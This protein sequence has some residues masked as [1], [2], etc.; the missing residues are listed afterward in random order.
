MNTSNSSGLT[1]QIFAGMPV[2][3]I[4]L[5]RVSIITT[6]K[7]GKKKIQL[8]GRLISKFRNFAFSKN[9]LLR[10]WGGCQLEIGESS[11]NS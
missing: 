6:Q 3:R 1:E 5:F 7:S 2:M 4:G 9:G 8:P 11:T 10:E